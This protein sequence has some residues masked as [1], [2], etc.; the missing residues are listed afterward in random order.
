MARI[1]PARLPR[2][3]RTNP[4]RAAECSI[5]EKLNATLGADW[6][7]FYSRPWLGLTATGEEIDGEADFVVAHPDQGIL[8]IEVKGGGIAYDPV[9]DQWTSRNRDGIV[10]DIKDPVQQARG[11]KYQILRQLNRSSHWRPH[12]VRARYGVVF[13]DTRL[14]NVSLGTDKP[15]AIFADRNEVVAD[16]GSWVKARLAAPEHDDR[17][18]EAPL[19]PPGIRALEKLLAAPFHLSVP[20]GHYLDDDDK[21]IELLTERQYR[22]LELIKDNPRVLIK[23][24]AGTGKTV[25]AVEAARRAADQGQK[26]LLTCYNAALAAVL[27]SRIGDAVDVLSFH[28]LCSTVAAKAGLSPPA[29]V[30]TS[31]L[32]EH[33]LPTLLAEGAS[34]V[35]DFRYQHI[36]VDEGQDFR[37][38]WWPAL[39]SLLAPAGRLIVFHDSNQRLYGDLAK[40]PADLIAVPISLN[41]C[42]RNTKRIHEL[43]MHHYKGEPVIGS[44]VV[45]ERPVAVVTENPA[46]V[47]EACRKIVTRLVDVERI[48]LEDIVILI[49]RETDRPALCKAGTLGPYA[50]KHC[51]EIRDGA[52]TVD[53]VERFKGL[54]GKAVILIASPQLVVDYDSAYV[55]TSRARTHLIALGDRAALARLGFSEA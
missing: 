22:V 6:V 45:G 11:S 13:P 51:D 2:S 1:W 53:T 21:D 47:T 33:H 48:A 29:A 25:L 49:A 12:W 39:D 52:I 16:I 9:S 43:V 34:A 26:V 3:V 10:F 42:L 28:A 8:T 14:G 27:K 30:S 31:D 17:A 46:A 37:S 24:A 20:L 44:D 32:Y 38:H 36:I 55:A 18:S 23:G 41:Q 35:P 19:G 4:L 7:V 5:Y 15:R 50:T 54:D 40:L